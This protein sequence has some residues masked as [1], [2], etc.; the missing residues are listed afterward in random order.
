MLDPEAV[1]FVD[2]DHTQPAK[3]YRL[4]QQRMSTDDDIYVAVRQPRQQTD[5]LAR[6]G[7]VGEQ[8]DPH[9]PLPPQ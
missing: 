1:L 3:T 5:P 7:A 9:L 6:R 4:G 2:H 8:L